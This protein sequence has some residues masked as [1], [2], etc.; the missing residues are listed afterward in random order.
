MSKSIEINFGEDGMDFN[1]S[2]SDALDSIYKPTMAPF[3]P[4]SYSDLDK[5][6]VYRLDTRTLIN[7]FKDARLPERYIINKEAAILFW[8]DGTKTIVKRAEDDSFNPRIAFLTAYFQAHSG[9][10]KTKAN[11]Y[12]KDLKIEPDSEK[13]KKKIREKLDNAIETEVIEVSKPV[14]KRAK[15]SVRQEDRDNA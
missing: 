11:K 8:K 7:K 4:I 15:K 10:S 12:L 13:V 14:K 6:Y 1:K 2:L 3:Q 5:S 9:M